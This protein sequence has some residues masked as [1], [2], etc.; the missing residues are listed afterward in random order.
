MKLLSCKKLY[1]KNFLFIITQEKF[2][3][4]TVVKITVLLFWVVSSYRIVGRYQHFG[5]LTA[6]ICRAEDG[7]VSNETV[8]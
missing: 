6:S 8:V 5:E 4:L 3:V 2:A 7:N 1:P